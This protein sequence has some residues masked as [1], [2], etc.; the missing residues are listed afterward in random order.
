MRSVLLVVLI[1]RMLFVL[2]V[3][4]VVRL[5][6]VALMEVVL[7]V[8][9]VLAAPMVLV[10]GTG[11]DTVHA[12]LPSRV[13]QPFWQDGNASIR[14]ASAKR[15]N[16]KLL[17]ALLVLLALLVPLVLLD[18]PSR[19]REEEPWQCGRPGRHKQRQ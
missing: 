12:C 10:I 8:P 2:S 16:T 3:A 14:G 19:R 17:I 11:T 15:S 9:E 6:L 13:K 1:V 7:V 18:N 4:Q 5:A